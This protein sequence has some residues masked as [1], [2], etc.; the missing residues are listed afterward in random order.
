MLEPTGESLLA[1]TSA[2]RDAG[3]A[4]IYLKVLAANDNSKNQAYL[5]GDFRAL[6]ML[7]FGEVRGERG[8][9]GEPIFKA[10][11]A[12]GWLASNGAV[13]PAPGAQLILYPQY[14]EVRLSGF[15]RGCEGAPT[16]LMGQLARIPGRVLFLGVT[17]EGGV[18]AHVVSPDSRAAN[19]LRALGL[20]DDGPLLV[21]AAEL[22]PDDGTRG[23]LLR[24]LRSVHRK[25]WITPRRLRA[26]GSTVPSKGPNSGGYTLEAEM[27]VAANGYA[28]PDYMGWELKQ[29][30]S[31]GADGISGAT[32]TLMT[33]EPTGGVYVDAGAKEFVLRYGYQDKRGREGRRNFGGLHLVGRT[34][35]STGLTM[36]LTGYDPA[37]GRIADAGG[38]IALL[39]SKDRIAASWSF[40]GLLKHWSRK[41]S[42]AAYVES[43]KQAEPLAYRFGPRA[44]LAEG[45]DFGLLLKGFASGRVFYDPGIKLLKAGGKEELK[46]RSQ[47][48]VRGRDLA[49]LYRTFET[50]D[51]S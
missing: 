33:P 7:P 26:D 19:E 17:N 48:R 1:V 37:A 49:S 25:G 40:S 43:T 22:G 16:H 14:P 23:V 12:F 5:G 45:T 13:A 51:L 9:H 42:A 15:L 20:R 6:N 44:R 10:Q 2:L 21:N 11:L 31:A 29:H 27:G 50:V 32:L 18:V 4:R 28:E 34:A 41:H 38:A 24:M 47:F 3:A 30:Q 36:Q 39:D 46:R 35:S 8:S